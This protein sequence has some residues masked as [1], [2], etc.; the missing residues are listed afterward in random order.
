[1]YR[2]P[3]LIGR[4]IIIKNRC[5]SMHIICPVLCNSNY[6]PC[7]SLKKTDL[8]SR[9]HVLKKEKKKKKAPPPP[10]KLNNIKLKLDEHWCFAITL[11]VLHIQN[12]IFTWLLLVKN[13]CSDYQCL[14]GLHRECNSSAHSH[15][16]FGFHSNCAHSG[17]TDARFKWVWTSA[18]GWPSTVK[19]QTFICQKTAIVSPSMVAV[20]SRFWTT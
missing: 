18:C 15:L 3:A 1:M 16:S 12:C 8:S 2:K 5:F 14:L 19:G 20:H 9:L 11:L 6:I 13:G 10:P 17:W 4:V 7:D